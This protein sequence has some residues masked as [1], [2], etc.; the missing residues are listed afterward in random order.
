MFQVESEL[1][2]IQSN[3]LFEFFGFPVSTTVVQSFFNNIVFFIFIF[4]VLYK[5][6]V[7]NLTKFQS[8]IEIAYLSILE[9]IEQI[10][11]DKVIAKKITPIAFTIISFVLVSNLINI[12]FPFLP[13]LTYEGKTLVRSL[14]SD[15]NA[16]LSLAFFSVILIQ[17]ENI[18]KKGFL[19]YLLDFFQIDKLFFGILRGVQNFFMSIINAFI[20]ILDLIS[21]FAKVISMSLRLFGN[22]FAGEILL[23]IFMKMFAIILPV[24]VLGLALLS[25]TIQSL[26]FGALITAYLSLIYKDL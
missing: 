19:R 5:F 17:I 6:K 20:G 2:T 9:F 26:V 16:T 25:G 13:A 10:A 21:E 1:L 12:L 15:I 11:G 7:Y 8:F 4:L 22:M 18:K 23:N 14:T 24:P 3:I